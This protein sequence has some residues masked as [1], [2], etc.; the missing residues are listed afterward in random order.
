MRR[1]TA[2][3]HELKKNEEFFK[4]E[5]EKKDK[6]YKDLESNFVNKDSEIMKR[7]QFLSSSNQMTE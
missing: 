2:L 7:M 5:L 4:M 3:D 6:E 1:I